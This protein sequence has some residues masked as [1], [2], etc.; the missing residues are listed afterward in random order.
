MGWSCTFKPRYQSLAKFFEDHGV[1]SCSA[2]LPRTYRVLDTA[3]VG[4]TEFYAALEIVEKETGAGRVV[5][6]IILIRLFPEDRDGFNICYKD[7]GLDRYNC[8]ERILNLLTPTVSEDQLSWEKTC[9]EKIEA[10]KRIPRLSKGV[11]MDFS[12]PIQ[13][14]SGPVSRLVVD[15]VRGQRIMCTDENKYQSYRIKRAWLNEEANAGRV[16]FPQGVK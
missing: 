4:L 6:L 2:D 14:S 7:I 13:F 3:F 5:P 1:L 10:R 9:R 15:G 16:S 8:P 11:V 12:E